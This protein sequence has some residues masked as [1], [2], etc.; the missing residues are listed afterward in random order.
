VTLILN[1]LKRA[2][3]EIEGAFTSTKVEAKNAFTL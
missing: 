1:A 2:V 3:N